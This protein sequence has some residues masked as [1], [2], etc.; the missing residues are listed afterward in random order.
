MTWRFALVC[1]ADLRARNAT[2]ELGGPQALSPLEAVRVF[3]EISG[4]PFEI[5]FVPREQLSEQLAVG[6]NSWVR[7][8]AGLRRC[9]A[10]NDV[11]DMREFT[12]QFPITLTSVRDHAIRV[13]GSADSIRH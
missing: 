3:E 1:L 4:R 10:D 6:E 9:Y 13:M 12:R 5:K 8:V 7:S 2:F 11:V